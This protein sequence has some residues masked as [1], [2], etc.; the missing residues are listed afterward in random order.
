MYNTDSFSSYNRCKSHVKPRSS[1]IPL[2]T[3]RYG[4]TSRMG[5]IDLFHIFLYLTLCRFTSYNACCSHINPKPY[6]IHWWDNMER[7]DNKKWVSHTI[8][9]PHSKLPPCN[10][11]LKHQWLACNWNF[12]QISV[13]FWG[14][15]CTIPIVFLHTTDAKVIS[16]HAFPKYRLGQCGMGRH[17][18]WAL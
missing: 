3:I 7:A 17:L 13:C 5:P 6:T 10:F 14:Y 8:F 11:V 15:S 9:S 1:E 12:P 16:S 2:G 18:E 4:S